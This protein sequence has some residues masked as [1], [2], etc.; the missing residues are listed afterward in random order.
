[1]IDPVTLDRIRDDHVYY[2]AHREGADPI[3][4][5]LTA[6]ELPPANESDLGTAQAL[7]GRHVTHRTLLVRPDSDAG[8][9][10]YHWTTN[11]PDCLNAPVR[12]GRY[13]QIAPTR[14]PDGFDAPTIYDLHPDLR[15]FD[16]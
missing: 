3:V 4:V 13:R 9:G 6:Y 10:T 8:G 12:L 5:H 2:P 7:C 16:R 14:A 1:M 11:C 15:E